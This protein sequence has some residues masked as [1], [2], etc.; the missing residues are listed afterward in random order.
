AHYVL[1]NNFT[2]A[3][4]YLDD[5]EGLG[6]NIVLLDVNLQTEPGGLEFLT[7][8]R[9]HPVG[10][11]VPIIILTGITS[12]ALAFEAYRR[13]TNAFTIKPFDYGDWKA[14]VNQLRT[15]WFLTATVPRLYFGG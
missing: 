6:P 5:L 10:C 1:V 9:K 8:M 3:S 4:R 14:Y 7:Q 2:E 13:G 11:L 12:K 15:F